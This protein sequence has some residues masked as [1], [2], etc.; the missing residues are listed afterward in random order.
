MASDLLCGNLLSLPVCWRR[1]GFY[2]ATWSHFL[3]PFMLCSFLKLLRQDS[4]N[5]WTSKTWHLHCSFVSQISFRSLFGKE[6]ALHAILCQWFFHLTWWV[7]ACA[8]MVSGTV[9]PKPIKVNHCRLVDLSELRLCP[10]TG[11]SSGYSAQHWDR[12]CLV[13]LALWSYLICQ[14]L[15]YGML[16]EHHWNKVVCVVHLNLMGNY[17]VAWVCGSQR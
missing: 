5:S 9:D 7:C 8:Y 14:F 16:A 12:L 15:H 10:L 3:D 2:A 13:Y 6:C 4:W 1:L 17:R 11:M